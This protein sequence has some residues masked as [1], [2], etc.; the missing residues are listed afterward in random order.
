MPKRKSK[1]E[2]CS[3][4]ISFRVTEKEKSWIEK[5]TKQRG[6]KQKE[7]IMESLKYYTGETKKETKKQINQAACVCE[8]QAFVNHLKRNHKEDSYAEEVCKKL[9]DLLN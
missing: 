6:I 7:L 4:Q 5:N 2:L 8:V 3:K 1:K 9:W